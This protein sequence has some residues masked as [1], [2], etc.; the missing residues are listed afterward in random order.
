MG[1]N[2][3]TALLSFMAIDLAVCLV[4]SRSLWLPAVSE[5]TRQSLSL[6]LGSRLPRL[7]SVFWLRILLKRTSEVTDPAGGGRE[8]VLA[9]DGSD[10]HA[11]PE[12]EAGSVLG[13][14]LYRKMPS[15]TR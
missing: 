1:F 6:L 3:F 14:G 7:P 8:R 10:P 15:P 9:I 4:S 2:Q 13:W 5:L 11:L 12:R